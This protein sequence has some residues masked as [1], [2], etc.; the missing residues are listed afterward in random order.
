MIVHVFRSLFLPSSAVTGVI[1]AI[2]RL[3]RVGVIDEFELGE[4]DPPL[5]D[6]SLDV[7]ARLAADAY[8]SAPVGGRVGLDRG[9]PIGVVP[10][11]RLGEHMP[12]TKREHNYEIIIIIDICTCAISIHAHN[13][14]LT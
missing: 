9:D 11:V 13:A 5:T 1:E 8:M 6:V 3:C 12:G 2:R 4:T 7:R 14:T 10:G